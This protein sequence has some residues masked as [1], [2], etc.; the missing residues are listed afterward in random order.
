[1][2]IVT[3]VTEEYWLRRLSGLDNK[4]VL[5]NT[6]HFNNGN[7]LVLG[8]TYQL[9]KDT[10][11]M[12]KRISNNSDVG[13]YII[14]L[15]IL[16][17]QLF[18]YSGKGDFSVGS[19]FFG[20]NAENSDYLISREHIDENLLLSD[21]LGIVKK[22]Y[23]DDNNHPY[24][25]FQKIYEKL[26][27]REG[28]KNIELFDIALV[29]EKLFSGNKEVFKKFNILMI[30][31]ENG[32]D[33]CIDV[34]SR[35][36]G[37]D[38]QQI[39]YFCQN[40][41][42]NIN[43][44]QDNYTK[45]IKDIDILADSEKKLIL[46]DFN[47]TDKDFP[48]NKSVIDLFENQLERTPDKCALKYNGEELSY[49][50]LNE[51]A[52]QLGR[53]L[54]AKGVSSDMVVPIVAE[55]S[56]ELIIGLFGI[57]KAGGAYLPIDTKY[58]KERMLFLVNECD[59]KIILTTKQI[60]HFTGTDIECIDLRKPD[61]YTGDSHNILKDIKPNHL[62]YVIYTS[63]STGNPKGVMIEHQA[64]VNRL[65]W[66]QNRY[67][68]GVNDVILQK[69]SITFDVSVWE[70][71]WWALQGSTLSLL[72]VDGEKN[73]D[74][75][76]KTIEKDKVTTM[77]FVPSMLSVFLDSLAFCKDIQILKS[78]KYVFSSGEELKAFHVNNFHDLISK[79]TG[80][81]LINLYGPTE[82]TVDVSYYDC[83]SDLTYGK[84]PIGKPI[85]N[86]NLM[87]LDK[88]FK[89]VPIGVMGELCI[90]GTGLARGYLKNEEFTK[91]KF[92]DDSKL[93]NKRFYRTGDY[94][95]WRT[96]GNI[97]FLGRI[98]NQF[99]IRGFRVEIGE[100][101]R[102][103]REHDSI[104]E[105]IVVPRTNK[106]E[107]K[108]LFTYYIPHNEKEIDAS[109]IKAYLSAKLPAY[110][111]P[112]IFIKIDKI[113]LTLNGKV[114]VKLL[115]DSIISELEYAPPRDELQ[116]NLAKIC[117]E[118]LESDWKKIGIN[119]S[120]FMLGGNSIKIISLLHKIKKR[121]N[122]DLSID[123]IFD[124]D[125][126]EKLSELITEGSEK[127][128]D[129]IVKVE[130]KDYYPLSSA[131]KRLFIIQNT[132]KDNIGY[133]MLSAFEIM[134]V[135][136]L[137]KVQSIFD[138]I[139]QRHENLRTSFRIIDG[140]P[141]QV[142][143]D[144]ID[145]KIEFITGVKDIAKEISDFEK[146]FNLLKDNL[147]RVR[148]INTTSNKNFLLLDMHHIISDGLSNGIFQNE[149][150]ALYNKQKL[151]GLLLQYKDY[152]NWEQKFVSGQSYKKQELFWFNQFDENPEYSHIPFD[153]KRPA[154]QSY[155]GASVFELI[156]NNQLDSLKKIAADNKLSLYILLLSIVNILYSKKTDTGEVSLGTIVHGR[157]H[158]D[159][160]N[161][162]GQF[163]NLLVIKSSVDKDLGF[164]EH[165]LETKRVV[166]NYFNN[167]QFHFERLV[168]KKYTKRDMAMTPFFNTL[169]TYENKDEI[170]GLDNDILSPYDQNIHKTNFD[171]IITIKEKMEGLNIRFDYCTKIYKKE[172]ILQL[173]F[174][175]KEVINAVVENN[176]IQI[177][178]IA[179]DK[180][181]NDIEENAF[182]NESDDFQF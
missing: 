167:Q 37:M 104:K 182:L 116:V 135:I 177:E 35:S 52:N 78:L 115:P 6:V 20:N 122:V 98:D 93:I 86:I 162:M 149:F 75:I 111:I 24:P 17:Y 47:N 70:L 140:I 108:Q 83:Q 176:N 97:E 63:G 58:P 27:L 166:L 142:I 130:K 22:S 134:S 69:T 120:F 51:K 65:N 150:I 168:E 36:E 153:F 144:K 180:N 91:E 39:H 30:L 127:R 103:I 169:F 154:I 59:A 175:F 12:L 23:I 161:V 156:E 110:M 105:V 123:T 174:N 62:A 143:H 2:D 164:R 49:R 68:I 1:M 121:F 76:L 101:E 117:A 16:K 13:T 61:I 178:D 15:S 67:P 5:A 56:F 81:K 31:K 114:D 165:L 99:K 74:L 43:N 95:K 38:L 72:P 66:M 25:S 8:N 55:R 145:L 125:T 4:G 181:L 82:A 179:I 112:D 29:S 147:L 57:L 46:S 163:I 34:Y 77:H 85:D 109:K 159:L 100:I 79:E 113:P 128:I 3:K 151:P 80:A 133:N 11:S 170:G 141:V 42:Q 50:E 136:V 92:I 89:H 131:Q 126:I 152:S 158:P 45:R 73:P 137:E 7:D 9:P 146:P 96:D 41:V 119:D 87:I 26:C 155:E 14:L 21:V 139:L 172:T 94:A 19:V 148:I 129:S 173:L 10:I 102:N 32:E 60:D 90:A 107:E 71:F 53:L 33:F 84:V 106:K 138:I 48:K 54:Q 171:I 124:Y 64:L 28:L 160:E 40:Y 118:V 88:Q 157:N 18:L 132:F 44:F